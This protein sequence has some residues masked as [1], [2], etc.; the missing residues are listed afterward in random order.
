MGT[1]AVEQFIAICYENYRPVLISPT[2]L[3]REHMAGKISVA[4][5]HC[6]MATGQG[7]SML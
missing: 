6:S 4:W 3:P 7:N 1:V 5:T 2:L